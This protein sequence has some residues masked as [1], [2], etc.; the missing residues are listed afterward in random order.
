M[1]IRTAVAPTPGHD[2][3][4]G[5]LWVVWLNWQHARLSGG[6]FA[7][8]WDDTMYEAGC[9]WM[10]SHSIQ[11]GM[12][13]VRQQL[14]WMGMT[15]DCEFVSSGNHEAHVEACAK[16]GYRMPQTMGLLP[17]RAHPV[18]G[19]PTW[20]Q[21]GPH[22]APMMY[23]PGLTTCW[24]VD[25]YLSGVTGLYTGA[26]WLAE[27]LHYEDICLRLGYRPPQREY[28]PTV[29]R[30]VSKESKSDGA[31][32]L[33]QLRDAGYEP[34]QIISTL[35][36]CERRATLQ[37]LAQVM[38]PYGYLTPQEVK[39]LPYEGDVI[40]LQ[41]LITGYGKAAADGDPR[42]VHSIDDIRA[43]CELEISRD[44]QRQRSVLT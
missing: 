16:L 9:N 25:D 41:G 13:R 3:H 14:D 28:V 26:E 31:F 21:S 33:P 1:P 4:V 17:R 2:F 29:A 5:N 34:W 19:M 35:R 11:T 10:S 38:I 42:F 12:D 22:Y 24:V 18:M 43:R 44:L 32:T 6:E 40:E 37:G 20:Q 27:A 7:L 30:G 36:E 23:Q 39:W 15:P 8:I